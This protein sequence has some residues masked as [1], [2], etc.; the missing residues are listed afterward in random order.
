MNYRFK[1]RECKQDTILDLDPQKV[2]D[3][4]AGGL[5]Q[6]VFPELS[7]DVRELM[8]SGYCGK[9]FDTLFQDEE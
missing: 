7:L 4:R 9:C 6:N 5:I 8:I 2:S 1:C 3:W